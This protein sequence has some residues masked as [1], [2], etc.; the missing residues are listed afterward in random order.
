M[1]PTRG[2]RRAGE[3]TATTTHNHKRG[4]DP[5]FRSMPSSCEL[6]SVRSSRG[7]GTKIFILRQ[8]IFLD[9]R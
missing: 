6:S 8:P 7:C 4:M 3:A 9:F 1:S 2:P 5:L